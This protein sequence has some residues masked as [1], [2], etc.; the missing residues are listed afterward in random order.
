MTHGKERRDGHETIGKPCA[1]QGSMA[2]ALKCWRTGIL[3]LALLLCG[4][5]GGSTSSGE[6]KNE[7][8]AQKASERGHVHATMCVTWPECVTE[9]FNKAVVDRANA[10]LPL[11]EFMGMLSTVRLQNCT[12]TAQCTAENRI[13]EIDGILQ[14]LS[15]PFE[16]KV[17]NAL[18][19]R[20][21]V[22]DDLWKHW[23]K[24]AQERVLDIERLANKRDEAAA[25]LADIWL[26]R[27]S[28]MAL[29]S[30]LLSP[31]STRGSMHSKKNGDSTKSGEAA[32]PQDAWQHGGDIRNAALSETWKMSRPSPPPTMTRD[33]EDFLVN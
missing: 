20:S 6:Q 13:K 28:A 24:E 3:F 30:S 33:G 16:E 7:S 5:V 8:K 12:R 29:D 19:A 21:K 26:R 32:A 15:K 9:R 1:V 27:M 23:T 18:A 10:G 25:A 17:S 2:A 4:E 11:A 22:E 31:S 14:N